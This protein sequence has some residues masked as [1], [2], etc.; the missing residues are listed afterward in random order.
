MMKSK[1]SKLLLSSALC[2]GIA[3]SALAGYPVNINSADAPQIAE[4]LDGVGPAKAKA[5]VEYREANG[6]YTHTDDL[7]KVK[8]IGPKMLEKNREFVQLE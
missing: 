7:L 4:A 8:G 5:I 2:F 6:P 1:I 3:S